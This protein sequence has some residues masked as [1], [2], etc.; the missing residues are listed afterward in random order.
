MEKDHSKEI[1]M[2]VVLEA[3]KEIVSR[4]EWLIEPV[5]AAGSNK[6]DED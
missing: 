1:K 6:M 2:M 5:G 3:M 4:K